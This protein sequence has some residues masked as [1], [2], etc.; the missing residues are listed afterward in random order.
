MTERY[1][2]YPKYKPSGVEWFSDLP[3]NWEESK[4]RYLFSFGKGLSITKANLQDS[5][6]PCVSYGEIHS[7]YGFEVDPDRHYL[8]C[9]SEVYLETNKDA[10]LQ[11]W[12][13]VF[14]DTSEDIE[15][16]GNFTQ[17]IS[18]QPVFAGYHT[19]IVRS[20]NQECCRFFAYLFNS[21]EWRS[22][23]QH[24]VKGVKVFSITQAILKGT[25]L[26]LPSLPE[27]RAI[28][29]FLDRE[30]G[31]IDR[32]IAKQERMIEL[33]KEKRQAVISHA[34]TKGLDPNV[35]MKDSGI[36]WLG[37]IPVDWSFTRLKFIVSSMDQ[38][39]SPQ[40]EARCVDVG[41]Y[42]VTKVGCVNGGFFR[43]LEHKTLPADITPRC[44]YRLKK[45]QLLISRANTLEL[46]GSAA[47]VDQNYD[48]LLLC[49]KIYRLKLMGSVDPQLIAYILSTRTYRSQIELGANGA[50][51][52]MQNIGQATIRELP[53]AI[54]PEKDATGIV[55][56]IK[57][58]SAFIDNLITKAEQ[59]IEL[60]KERRTSLISAAVTGKIDV[61]E[62]AE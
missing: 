8:K 21:T 25:N 39:W 44:E 55:D 37:E 15:G 53:M 42:G 11:E 2:P 58:Q 20:I 46:V 4:A 6:I 62:V 27:Q 34:V 40:C 61:R 9:V 45:D 24:M 57:K 49:D 28:A 41:E 10:L 51:D 32:L 54:P 59:A 5:G 1:K 38:G 30:T 18:S 7:K 17:L 12:D 36:E 43:P 26:C 29:S 60:M 16:S 35:P 13:F 31:K 19:V 33:L 50:S 56:F 47:V 22:Q 48:W 52:S 23:V 14:A 3:A